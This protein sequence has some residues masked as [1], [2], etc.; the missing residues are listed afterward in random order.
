[1]KLIANLSLLFTERPLVERFA[2]A[3]RAGFE[4]VEIQFPYDVP[5]DVLRA[6][7]GSLPIELINVRSAR[8]DGV[9]IATDAGGR[10][11]FAEELDRTLRYAETLGV[12]K[13]N[14]LAWAP[15]PGQ[16]ESETEAALAGNVRLAA[17]RLSPR[18]IAVVVECVNPVDAPGFWLRDVGTSL[19]FLDRLGDDRVRFQLD[20]YHMARTEPDLVGAIARAGPRIGHLQFA[21]APGRHEPGTG[22]IHFGSAFAALR[23]AGYNGAVS[24]EYRPVGRTEDGLGWMAEVPAWLGRDRA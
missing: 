24:A 7:A 5:A 15:P 22:A 18:G 21:D 17:E 3:A 6:A 4:G 19:G 20:F 13:V 11:L 16:S 10:A 1:M 14:V 2:A 8:P 23:A 12:R 9:G